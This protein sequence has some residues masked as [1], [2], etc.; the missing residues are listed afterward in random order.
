MKYMLLIY[1]AEPTE[2]PS[3]ELQQEIMDAYIGYTKEIIDAGVHVSGDPLQ[4]VETATT[5]ST[6]S[7]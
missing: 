1:G 5:F 6:T 2:P 3:A 7:A 4:G